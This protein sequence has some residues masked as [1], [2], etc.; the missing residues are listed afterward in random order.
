M[1]ETYGPKATDRDGTDRAG[2]PVGETYL[3]YGP[4][5][6]LPTETV[7]RFVRQLHGAGRTLQQ[8]EDGRAA[9]ERADGEESRRLHYPTPEERIA[10]AD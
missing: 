1:A 9:W 10:D 8:Y 5:Y 4:W 7:R 2:Q 3:V 6:G